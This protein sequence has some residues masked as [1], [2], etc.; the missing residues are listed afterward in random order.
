MYNPLLVTFITVADCGSFNKASIKLHISP[1]AIMKQINSLENHLDLTL[2][3][4]TNSG[5]YLTDS[6]KEIYQSAKFIIDYSNKAIINAKSIENSLNKTFYIGTSLLN[7][8]KPIMDLWYEI[9]KDFNEYNIH[10][11]PFED[12]YDDILYEIK[13]LGDKFDILIGVC[14]SKKWL[15]ICNFSKL[16]EYKKMV[17]VSRD[18]PLAKKDILN[19]S[20]LYGYTL[21]MVQKGDSNI[22]DTIRYDL[23]NYHPQI[24]IEDT[25]SFYDLS[26]F[27]RCYETNNI[28]L[29]IECWKD[30]HPGLVSI[31]VLW[32]YAIPYG[33]LYSKNAKDN[34][35]DFIN[36]TVKLCT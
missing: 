26:V 13:K 19:I 8:A 32:D 2:I 22:N 23:E 11:V 34:V 6:G 4:R 17:A 24:K 15:D 29:T 36:A 3:K 35:I 28:L 33:L 9:K 14:D 27:N 30:V 7:P 20:D 10:L 31:P 18:H 1:T 21:I 5:V 16:G 12:T 25:Q